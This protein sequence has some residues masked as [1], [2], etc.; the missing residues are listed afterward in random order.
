MPVVPVGVAAQVVETEGVS[1]GVQM[2]EADAVEV[3]APDVEVNGFPAAHR[4]S[5]AEMTLPLGRIRRI[6]HAIDPAA[7]DIVCVG[8]VIELTVP[9]QCGTDGSD[10]FEMVSF[11]AFLSRQV[12]FG[13]GREQGHAGLPSVCDTESAQRYPWKSST[14]SG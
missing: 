4:Q 8:R 7:F 13:D 2:G 10:K 14:G 9:R 1:L 11:V 6:V 12:E 5:D 3:V